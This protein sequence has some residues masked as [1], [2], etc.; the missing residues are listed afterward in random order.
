[1]KCNQ[2][3]PR[4]E[5]VSPC[6]FP[7]MITIIPPLFYVVFFFSFLCSLR[8]LVLMHQLQS[9]NPASHLPPT[10]LDTHSLHVSFLG[11]KVLCIIINF[12]V[13]SFICRSSSLSLLRIVPSF[14]IIPKMRFLHSSLVSI[15]FLLRLSFSFLFL[16]I[17]FAVFP[18]VYNRL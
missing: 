4:F 2:S 14:F 7:M 8:V 15:S 16:S 3:R 12:L 11:S 6:P 10:L 9:S 18:T 13:I 5:L 1:M 17:V